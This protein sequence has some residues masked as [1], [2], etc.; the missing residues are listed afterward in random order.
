MAEFLRVI[1]IA[2]GNVVHELDVSKK[3]QNKIEKIYN[4]ILINLNHAKFYVS[5]ET[6]PPK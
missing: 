4:G 1:E 5:Q 2:T 6:E 3:S